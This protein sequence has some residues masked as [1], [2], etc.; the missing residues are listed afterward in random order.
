MWYC[1]LA[2]VSERVWCKYIQL[3]YSRK[4]VDFLIF[5]VEHCPR[6]VFDVFPFLNDM[7]LQTKR[8]ENIVFHSR[9]LLALLTAQAGNVVS[10]TNTFPCNKM[11]LVHEITDFQTNYFGKLFEGD[12]L[13]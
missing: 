9:F 8:R 5:L 12:P 6:T 13:C 10:T 4:V 3:C 2:H 11:P 7:V 1:F